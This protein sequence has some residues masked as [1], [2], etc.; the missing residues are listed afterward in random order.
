MSSNSDLEVRKREISTLVDEVKAS[1]RHFRE[2][3]V[4]ISDPDEWMQLRDIVNRIER[5]LLAS[6]PVKETA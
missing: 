4:D 1:E 2:Q 3:G 5:R 6:M